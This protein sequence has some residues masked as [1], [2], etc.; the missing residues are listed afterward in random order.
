MSIRPHPPVP[1]FLRFNSEERAHVLAEWFDELGDENDSELGPV[2]WRLVEQEWS[3]FDAIDH[4]H[5]EYLFERF[6]PYWQEPK[7][8]FYR[9]LPDR[10][11]AYR[12]SD[13]RSPPGLS[14]TLSRK[15]ARSFARGHR[16]IR[17]NDPVLLGAI[18]DRREVALAFGDRSESEV[19]LFHPPSEYVLAEVFRP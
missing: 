6:R 15:V 7:C 12:G 16:G 11:V 9:S 5:Y 8:D 13:N 18:F 17:N 10:F 4:D 19:V 14:W 2:F 1:N 3:G